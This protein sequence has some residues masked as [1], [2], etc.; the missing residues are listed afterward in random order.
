MEN[1]LVCGYGCHLTESLK[2]YLDF[3]A[4]YLLSSTMTNLVITSG[5]YNNLKTAPGICEAHLMRDYFLAAG[6]TQKIICE[7]VART[8]EGNLYWTRHTL[9]NCAFDAPSEMLEAMPLK[10]FCDSI[11]KFKVAYMAKRIFKCPIQ[12]IGYDFGR[13]LKEK[14]AQSLVFTPIE[15]AAFHI[16]MLGRKLDEY[17]ITQNQNR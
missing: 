11:R 15:I 1:V 10:I 5:G 17:R 13:S 14:V 16:P 8:S 3:V 12:I 7:I 6:V 4:N 9:H 2:R